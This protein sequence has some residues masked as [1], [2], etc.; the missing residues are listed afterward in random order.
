MLRSNSGGSMAPGEAMVVLYRCA[1]ARARPLSSFLTDAAL[2]SRCCWFSRG[3][4]N[5]AAT[6]RCARAFYCRA[7]RAFFFWLGWVRLVRAL[8]RFLV[9]PCVNEMTNDERLR[10]HFAFARV[11]G[12]AKTRQ[13]GSS[14]LGRPPRRASHFFRD[15]WKLRIDT[16]LRTGVGLAS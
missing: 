12:R 15:T 2:L 7:V 9:L 6:A 1:S 8:E 3:L 13:R 4:G 10:S 5:A 16:E 11:V 14:R